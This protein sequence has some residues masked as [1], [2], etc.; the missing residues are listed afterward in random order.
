MNSKQ[1]RRIA[2]FLELLLHI[3]PEMNS[4]WTREINIFIEKLQDDK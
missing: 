1:K 4:D 2:F 3:N